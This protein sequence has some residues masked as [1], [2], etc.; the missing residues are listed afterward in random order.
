MVSEFSPTEVGEAPHRQ[1]IPAMSARATNQRKAP[2]M[3]AETVRVPTAGIGPTA[4][5]GSQR[6]GSVATAPVPGG[7]RTLLSLMLMAMIPVLLLGCAASYLAAEQARHS[8][9]KDAVDTLDLVASRVTS[10]LAKEIEVA[11]TLA[12][13]PS[14][15]RKD[16]AGF[17]DEA[18]RIVKARPLWETVSLAEASGTQL[19]NLLRPFG[20][21]LGPVADRQ[22][23]GAVV[24]TDRPIIGGIGEPG[25]STGKRL[26]ALGVPVHVNGETRF[27]LTV[28]L[29]PTAIQGV[30]LAAGA[31]EGWTGTMLD[32]AGNVVARTAKTEDVGVPVS[33]AVREASRGGEGFYTERTAKGD[34]V[35]TVFRRLPIAEGWTV[36]FG[37]PKDSLNAPVYR[38]I[39]LLAAGSLASLVLAAGVA[40]LTGRDLTHRRQS[41]Q[42]RA[43]LALAL[44]QEREA[45]A[46]QAAELGTWRWDAEA[47]E[48]SGSARAAQLVAISPDL[49]RQV[50]RLPLH[51]CLSHVHD[52]D[53]SR[54]EEAVRAVWSLG[55]LW[56][57]NSG[58][59]LTKE[60]CAG[61]GRKD[62]LSFRTAGSARRLT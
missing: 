58:S 39:Q 2:F 27:V 13:L 9:R 26:V 30:L 16:L 22:A 40:H 3:Q 62:A 54:V 33:E 28:G 56:T 24:R 29:S 31:P 23:F 19:L 43:S 50:G 6:S 46:V 20:D 25:P 11:Q 42:E 8:A 17:Y 53:R 18:S 7:R 38:S 10:E 41:E 21:G 48:I 34:E 37:I 5:G 47:D 1:V 45:L 4:S 36:H 51:L 32:G 44:S 15:G 49:A 14:L 61:L 52:A 60:R 57:L 12:A 55:P 59:C 35:E